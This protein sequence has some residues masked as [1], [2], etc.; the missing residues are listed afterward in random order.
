MREGN[1]CLLIGNIGHEEAHIGRYNAITGF[2]CEDK[3]GQG[4]ASQHSISEG[5]EHTFRLLFQYDI[6]E[7]YI[8]DL[9][10]QTYV[11]KPISSVGLL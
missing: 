7:L 9:L 6:F 3:I 1:N 4:C 5:V 8:D 10:V 11:Y 2:N